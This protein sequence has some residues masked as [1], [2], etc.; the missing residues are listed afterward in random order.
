MAGEIETRVTQDGISQFTE[1]DDERKAQYLKEHFGWKE[2]GGEWADV[3]HSATPDTYSGTVDDDGN[4]TITKTPGKPEVTRRV[5]IKYR[6][7]RD[8][9]DEI[10]A[11]LYSKY[12]KL[13][14]GLGIAIPLVCF[15]AFGGIQIYLWASGNGVL[16][17]FSQQ[18]QT[19]LYITEIVFL[20]FG[21][22]YTV[23]SAK[24]VMP[25][26]IRLL[27]FPA[28]RRAFNYKKK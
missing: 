15:L 8:V 13:A 27:T 5:K 28:R 19:A 7:C 6:L 24:S 4:V 21:I 11:K 10:Q 3:T 22:L 26:L 16:K 18:P 9:Q 2:C 12:E 14:F 25:L 20:L 23:L 17:D 1:T